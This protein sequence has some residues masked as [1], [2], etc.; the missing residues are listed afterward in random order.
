MRV[1]FGHAR[2]VPSLVLPDARFHASFAAAV[3][4]FQ[5][6][7]VNVDHYRLELHDRETFL[8][9]LGQLEAESHPDAIARFPGWVPQTTLWWVDETEYLGRVGIRHRLTEPLLQ[10]GGHIGYDVRP[11]ARRQG[12]ATAM[13]RASLATARALGIEKALV[14]CDHDNVA[15]RKVIEANGGVEDEPN[16]LKLRYWVDTTG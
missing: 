12:H 3:D 6:E 9:W 8:E 16:A 14:T 13:L 11:S 15:S 2:A 1:M 5:L 4:E 7:Q 10:F